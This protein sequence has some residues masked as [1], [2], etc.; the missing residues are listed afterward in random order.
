MAPW[1]GPNKSVMCVAC[2]TSGA[3]GSASC[4]RSTTEVLAWT[5]TSTR[6]AARPP[7]D[8]TDFRRP[9]QASTPTSTSPSATRRTSG[10]TPRSPSTVVPATVGRSSRSVRRATVASCCAPACAKATCTTSPDDRP[11]ARRY[12]QFTPPDPTRPTDRRVVSRVWTG[13]WAAALRVVFLTV[14]RIF[15][16][17][18]PAVLL[19]AVACS[20]S[21]GW[22]FSPR[23]TTLE[24]C[25]LS[26]CVCLSVCVSVGI[27]SKQLNLGS[28]K[29]QGI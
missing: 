20:N 16:A 23:D 24:R 6:R 28:R 25:M 11:R 14:Y 13:R 10:P 9:V 8:A 27:V 7:A 3:T 22:N 1:N 12:I 5:S 2:R 19:D 17:A 26:S 4:R 15:L 29:Q 21:V 18:S